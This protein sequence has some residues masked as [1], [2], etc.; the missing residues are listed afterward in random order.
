MKKSLFKSLCFIFYV[1]LC[2]ILTISCGIAQNQN[3]Q[4]K[5]YINHNETIGKTFLEYDL[6]S[7]N[8][9]NWKET[10]FKDSLIE[11]R[12][13]YQNLKFINTIAFRD[14]IC[15][16]QVI[17]DNLRTLKNTVDTVFS[18]K[19][20]EESKDYFKKMYQIDLDTST[21][22][23]SIIEVKS[24]SF[25]IAVGGGGRPTEYGKKYLD[26]Y[27]KGTTTEE[28]LKLMTSLNPYEQLCGYLLYNDYKHQIPTSVI[29]L[30]EKS[31]YKIDYR[32]GCT[33]FPPPMTFVEVKKQLAEY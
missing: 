10:T 32:Y 1:E 28:I 13:D 21:F 9:Q 7:A 12:Y 2:F 22:F 4:G 20:F 15:F 17:S 24:A 25:G 26:L 5:L 23:K 18:T 3:R 19:H 30:V 31:T 33:V 6:Q 11:V 29:D 8:V 14:T 16:V 27:S